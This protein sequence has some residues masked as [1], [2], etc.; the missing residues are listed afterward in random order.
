[1]IFSMFI[2]VILVP[3]TIFAILMKDV[4]KLKLRDSESYISEI[5]SIQDAAH[6][7]IDEEDLK[8]VRSRLSN[9]IA[10][11]TFT[12]GI[13]F[14]A[15][16][17][18]IHISGKEEVK[19]LYIILAF[20]VIV[21]LSGICIGISMK[22]AKVFQ[23]LNCFRKTKGCI[24]KYKR[25][26][27]SNIGAHK[28]V[29]LYEALI[30]FRDSDGNPMVVKDTLPE[31]IFHFAQKNGYCVVVLYKGNPATVISE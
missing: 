7:N 25:I 28:G 9:S 1:M 20:F 13:D 31:F 10:V 29:V 27:V 4:P 6:K 16:I 15:I 30:G 24:L 19:A 8:L 2:L 11:P 17:G 18:L 23:D 26:H 12:A 14:L 3:L 21:L 5:V 22:K